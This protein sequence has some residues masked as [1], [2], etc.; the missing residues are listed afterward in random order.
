MPYIYRTHAPLQH[1][2]FKKYNKHDIAERD[3]HNVKLQ[4]V[5]II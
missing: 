3:A 1:Q 4:P 5:D 2:K